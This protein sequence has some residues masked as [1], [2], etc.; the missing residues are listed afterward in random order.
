MSPYPYL[1]GLLALF[2][3]LAHAEFD[4]EGMELGIGA[5]ALSLPDYRGS[6]E[7]RLRVLPLPYFT[8]RSQHLEIDKGGLRGLFYRNDR[9]ELDLSI[10]ATP[11]VNSQDNAARAGMP[12]LD[13]TVE[14]GPSLKYRLNDPASPY[15]WQLALPLRASLGVNGLHTH[16]VGLVLNPKLNFDYAASD[17]H[18]Y[19]FS[20]GALF[21]DRRQ[22][23]YFYNVSAQDTRPERPA[24]QARAGYGGLQA[25]ASARYQLGNWWLGTFIRVD[26]ISGSA[27]AG[28]PLVQQKHNISAG[29]GLAWRFYRSGPLN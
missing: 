18:A 23:A 29:L 19:G 6:N 5:M 24:Y 28:S 17:R 14:A 25:T 10:N 26:E 2:P 7:Q 13:P 9:I 16:Q 11:P 8:Y 15:V 12:K 21:G 20:L 4:Q 1:L 3:L 27:F 22:H